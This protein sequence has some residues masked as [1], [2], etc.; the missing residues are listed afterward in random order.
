[1]PV[2]HATAIIGQQLANGCPSPSLPWHDRPR[3][4]RHPRRRTA[5]VLRAAGA[6]LPRLARALARAGVRPSE[7]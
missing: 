4:S 5:S 2:P 7:G 1:M 6:S 3:P